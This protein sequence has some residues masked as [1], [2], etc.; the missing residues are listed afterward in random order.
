MKKKKNK[1]QLGS[2]NRAPSSTKQF[3]PNSAPLIPTYQRD[4]SHRKTQRTGS[5]GDE[6]E[7]FQG[8]HVCPSRNLQ[9]CECA[10]HLRLRRK[11][12]RALGLVMSVSSAFPWSLGIQALLTQ[13]ENGLSGLGSLKRTFR[14]SLPRPGSSRPS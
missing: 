9:G 10:H 7:T 5:M 8:W 3:S 6:K 2:V 1:T 14:L 4:L 11:G 13:F 12:G